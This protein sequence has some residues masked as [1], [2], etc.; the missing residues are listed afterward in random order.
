MQIEMILTSL[1]T[2]KWCIFFCVVFWQEL[3]IPM[4]KW[5]RL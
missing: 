1:N 5:D 4:Q 2:I 3:L